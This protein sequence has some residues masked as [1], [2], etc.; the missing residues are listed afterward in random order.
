MDEEQYKST[1][2][3][4]IQNRKDS[5]Q[6]NFDIA[7]Q[8]LKKKRIRRRVFAFSFSLAT[9]AIVMIG[10]TF[11]ILNKPQ[12]GLYDPFISNQLAG[13]HGEVFDEDTA[14]YSELQSEDVI[15]MS[16]TDILINETLASR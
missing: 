7:S 8:V 5:E 10:V 4:A 1:M 11:G 12:Q 3:K 6:W 15:F 14:Y 9:A 13:T 2:R 16:E